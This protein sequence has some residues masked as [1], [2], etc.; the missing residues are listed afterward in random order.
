MVGI[1]YV[2]E[3][4]YLQETGGEY[5]RKGH[6]CLSWLDKLLQVH[7]G[8]RGKEEQS[9]ETTVWWKESQASERE[10][11]THSKAGMRRT[12]KT[13]WKVW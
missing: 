4:G 2:K 12:P 13:V 5:S 11:N 7:A 10:R 1:I 9:G 3:R 8:E 6:G